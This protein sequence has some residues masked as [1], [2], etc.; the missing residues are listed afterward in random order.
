[1]KEEIENFWFNLN[2]IQAV[3]LKSD[4]EF[5]AYLGIN[6]SQFSKKKATN[7]WLPLNAVFECAEKLNFHFNDLLQKNF[8]VDAILGQVQGKTSLLD[9]YTIAPYSK[10]RQTVNVLN[11]LT[12]TR[13]ERAKINLLRKF[14]LT[15]NYIHNINHD[16]NIH[17][18]M[19]IVKYVGETHGLS[20]DEFFQIGRMTPF[21]S[22]NIDIQQEL[23]DKKNCREM[24]EFIFSDSNTKRFD[25]NFL[26]KIESLN[27]EYAIIEAK[28]SK[29][30][31]E[32]LGVRPREFGSEDVCLTR[33]GVFSSLPWFKYKHYGQVT[34]I[35][36]IYA[37]DNTNFYKMDLSRFNSL[38]CFTST[39]AN[40][41]D[42]QTIYH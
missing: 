21:T 9:K 32:E 15:D 7:D 41:C 23:K 40:S 20:Q 25:R 19:D 31:M 37:G 16:V 36:S 24:M 4:K 3:L 5:A 12:Q 18:F 28:P 8:S 11:Y 29:T 14:Q 27:E 33:M 39:S 34:K 30:V 17:L 10:T 35:S 1:M 42:F 26:Y 13:G 38:S 2:K 22:M 6:Y